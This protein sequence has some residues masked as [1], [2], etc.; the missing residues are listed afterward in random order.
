V[1]ILATIV[2]LLGLV[3]ATP[4]AWPTAMKHDTGGFQGLPWGSLLQEGP[5][6]TKVASSALGSNSLAL[7]YEPRET[8]RFGNTT[9]DTV[10]YIAVDGRFARVSVTYHGRD[11]HDA[12]LAHLQSQHGE[13]DRM[14]G[15]MMRGLN[16]QYYW[17]GTDTQ[18]GVTYNGRSERG[19]VFIE[20]LT[21]APRFNDGINESGE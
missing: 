20:S 8:P 5:T 17:R 7:E 19:H 11:N 15:Q 2:S 16:Q 21:L 14:P 9:L 6:L 4:P 18:I 13:F 10:R 1:K 12:M 3:V